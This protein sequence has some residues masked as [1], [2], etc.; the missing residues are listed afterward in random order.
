MTNVM[1]VILKEEVA[2]KKKLKE[3]VSTDERKMYIANWKLENEV[4]LNTELGYDG[5]N[6]NQFLCG[7]LVTPSTSKVTAPFLHGVVQADGAHMS[8]GK[9]TL[10]TAYAKTA[11][12]NMSPLLYGILF[13]NEDKANWTTFWTCLNQVHPHINQS[14][15]TIMTDQDKGSIE[16]V[17]LIIPN[18]A[19]FFCSYHRRCNII[20]TC[21]GG[22]GYK[23]LSALWMFNLLSS[24]STI[25][26]IAQLKVKYLEKMFPTDRHYL[27]KIPNEF[28]YPAARCHLN[29][30]SCMHGAS[31]GDSI[32]KVFKYA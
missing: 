10:F 29:H 16:S 15:M 18:A 6:N 26:H 11:N 2:R 4:F 13:G 12:G 17:K 5:L 14:N 24:C 22:I 3:T 7:M 32:S 8:F 28:Q 9:N 19:Q 1:S 27:E 30:N 21:G 25:E 31:V 20:K 23:P